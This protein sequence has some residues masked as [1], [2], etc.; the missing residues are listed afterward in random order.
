MLS[1]KSDLIRHCRLQQNAQIGGWPTSNVPPPPHMVGGWVC[2][3]V[4]RRLII[5]HLC[6]SE[7]CQLS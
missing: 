5:L 4:E 2:V 7:E 3:V 1:K 6:I